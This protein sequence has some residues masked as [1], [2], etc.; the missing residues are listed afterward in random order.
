MWWCAIIFSFRTPGFF[1]LQYDV[2][3]IIKLKLKQASRNSR[4]SSVANVFYIFYVFNVLKLGTTTLDSKHHW[5]GPVGYSASGSSDVTSSKSCGKSPLGIATSVPFDVTL[6]NLYISNYRDHMSYVYPLK[7][8]GRH[9]IHVS[10][11]WS[12]KNSADF[13]R[14]TDAL[15]VVDLLVETCVCWK[16]LVLKSLLNKIAGL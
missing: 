5:K 2:Q 15:I 3:T 10:N 6:I 7:S 12:K 14:K 4:K 9:W 11:I 8:L 1:L 13:A 16:T